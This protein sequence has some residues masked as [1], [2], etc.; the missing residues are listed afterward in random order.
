MAGG[1]RINESPCSQ[2]E[3]L[4]LETSTWST[5]RSG[6]AGSKFQGDDATAS[7]EESLNGPAHATELRPHSGTLGLAACAAR[8]CR[9][10]EDSGAQRAITEEQL[11]HSAASPG[12][13]QRPRSLDMPYGYGI[14]VISPWDAPNPAARLSSGETAYQSEVKR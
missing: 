7:S 3:C 11:D 9:S 12:N 10:W 5:P 8:R 13:A 14:P 4:P 1:V 2:D 6:E